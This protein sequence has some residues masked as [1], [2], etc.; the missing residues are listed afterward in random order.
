VNIYY[1]DLINLQYNFVKKPSI[2]TAAKITKA[3]NV[4]VEDLII[5]IY[6]KHRNLQRYTAKENNDY[7]FCI[8][9]NLL[10]K[11]NPLRAIG[12]TQIKS[13]GVFLILMGH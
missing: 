1:T 11:L 4:S 10:L 3:V 5:K 13:I 2:Q 6:G 7:F 8:I 12:G 9:L